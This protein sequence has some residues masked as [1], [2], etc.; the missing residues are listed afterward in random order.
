VLHP[1]GRPAAQGAIA[2]LKILPPMLRDFEKRRKGGETIEQQD[3]VV[4]QG[5]K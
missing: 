4:A 3:L 5:P 2:G 1:P